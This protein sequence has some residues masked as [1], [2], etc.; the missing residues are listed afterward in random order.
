[1]DRSPALGPLTEAEG[2]IRRLNEYRSEAELNAAVAGVAD[3][4]ERSLRLALRA[5]PDAPED[6]RLSALAPDALP[7]AE[8]VRSLRARDVISLETAGIIHELEGSAR[9]AAAGEARAGDADVAARAVERL[10]GELG[11][12]P[13]T[14]PAA[15]RPGPGSS[16]PVPGGPAP[17]SSSPAPGGHAPTAAVRGRGRWMAWLGAAMALLFMLGLA[18]VLT[19]G[20]EDHY[21]AGMQAFRAER[22]DS[23]AAAF[24]RVLEE[25]PVDVTTMLYLAR[26]YRR[27]GRLD[28]AAEV[29]GEAMRVA[30]DDA[31]ARREMGRLFM[32]LGQPR[33]AIEQFE[34]ALES[35]PESAAT[36]AALVQALR[37]AGDP[38]S[39]RVLERAPPE[40]RA[41]LRGEGVRP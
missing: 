33:A 15:V 3:A 26:S 29:L 34:H 16:A 39:E 35:D 9:R 2:P 41:A 10:R 17:G 25:R 22:W 38:R 5:D 37:A 40:V 11:Q 31:D 30:S 20:G 19:S 12:T 27:A 24:E 4:V 7:L 28:R 13:S 18:W 1:M 14:E 23:A 32:D 21:R 8:V 6:H 36:W